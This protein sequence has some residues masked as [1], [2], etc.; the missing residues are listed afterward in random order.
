M[1]PARPTVTL[2]FVLDS[3]PIQGSMSDRGGPN[4]AFHGWIQLASLIQA[5]AR[6][7]APGPDPPIRMVQTPSEPP[8]PT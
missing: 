7:P 8:A 6:T 1:H 3:E 2:E 4:Q 5:A